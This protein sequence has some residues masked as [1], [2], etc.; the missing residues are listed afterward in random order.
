MM[1]DPKFAENYD[2]IV[3]RAHS[4]RAEAIRQGTNAVFSAIG[5]VFRRRK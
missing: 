2:R 3:A 4:M 5:G 1:N